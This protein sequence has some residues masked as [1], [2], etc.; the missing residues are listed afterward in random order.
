LEDRNARYH[1]EKRSDYRS[2]AEVDR[3]R[4]LYASAFAR[5]AE[6]TQVVS[7]DRG[8]V[9][10]NRLTH[11]LKVA[12]LARRLAQRLLAQ[13]PSEV[14]AI[15]GLDPD[16]AEAAA[17]AH[18]LGHPPHGHIAEQELN[19]LAQA[20]G[21]RDGFE[22]NAQSFRIVTKLG[23]SDAI[24]NDDKKDA[25][26]NN[27][28]QLRGLNLTRATLNAVLKYPWFHGENPAK[29]KKWGTYDTERESFE[30]T[31]RGHNLHRFSK[32]AE[33]ELM[34][35]ADDIT[36]AVHDV[37][38]FYCAGQ[39]PLN[40][41]ANAS[42]ASERQS[43]FDEV[44]ARCGDLAQRRAEL[45]NI[46]LEVLEFFPLDRRY[47]GTRKQRTALW[48]FSTVLISR[49][50]E[51][52]KLVEPSP[53]ATGVVQIE[54]YAQD[55][56]RMLKEL[57]WHYVIL[58]NEVATVQFGQRQAVRTV[59]ETMMKASENE[60]TWNLFPPLYQEELGEARND[61][62]LKKRIVVDYVASMTEHELAR[63]Y[64]ALTGKSLGT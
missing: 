40:Q 31:R 30:W 27:R 46:F 2:K 6:V 51:A 62:R 29:P 48:Q 45:E 34:D 42:D 59:F 3:D 23:V 11:S 64:I 22:G 60:K 14:V 56:I 15:G 12:Q 39:I 8:Y 37:S 13:Q 5:L 26:G 61:G 58:N 33:A 57:T 49:Y 50:V 41:L 4:V 9:F 16:V 47:D 25:S 28:K 10:H 17:L 1:T 63:I 55:E 32:S 18:D 54:L 19:Q 21:L 53:D 43:F 35:W 7:A 52:I 44:F 36:Y 24:A 20:A 38:D